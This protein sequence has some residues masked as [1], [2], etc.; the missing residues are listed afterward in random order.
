V[1]AMLQGAGGIDGSEERPDDLAYIV[2]VRDPFARPHTQMLD[3]FVLQTARD[4][5]PATEMGEPWR[6]WVFR[7]FL[8]EIGAGDNVASVLF[9]APTEMDSGFFYD[10]ARHG[11]D[12]Y[13]HA[14]M[15]YRRLTEFGYDPHQFALGTGVAEFRDRLPVVDRLG[16]LVLIDES[17]AFNYKHGSR[18]FFQRT[19]DDVSADYLMY[20]ICDETRHVF[21]GRRWLEP[22]QHAVGD[23]RDHDR[24]MADLE[25]GI[26]ERVA[27][28]GTGNR[29]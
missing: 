13:R 2:P 5:P 21:N 4:T 8:N 27:F 29:N 1:T 19:G 11:W 22:L 6:Q 17:S 15:G 14:M 23:T 26:A 28:L 7:N 20:D 9:D 25:R 10:I 24:L 12:E 16:M 18:K 3:G